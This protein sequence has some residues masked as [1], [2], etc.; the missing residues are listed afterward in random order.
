[1]NR[2]CLYVVKFSDIE[3]V[4]LLRGLAGYTDE[5]SLQPALDRRIRPDIA[6]YTNSTIDHLLVKGTTPF[7]GDVIDNGL[8]VKYPDESDIRVTQNLQLVGSDH[9]PIWG[10]VQI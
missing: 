10:R 8:W 7:S 5:Q 9:F 4:K 1:M 3:A 2:D 6:G